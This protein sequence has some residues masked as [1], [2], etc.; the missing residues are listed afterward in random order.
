MADGG[1]IDVEGRLAAGSSFSLVLLVAEPG[2][3]FVT[4]TA[5]LPA[6][7]PILTSPLA[8]SSRSFSRP[9]YAVV[10]WSVLISTGRSMEKRDRPFV[11]IES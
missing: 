10:W 4:A 1:R 3:P 2:S 7:V 5:R 9:R 8:V 6:A 11:R